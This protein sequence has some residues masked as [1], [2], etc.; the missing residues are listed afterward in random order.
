MVMVVNDNNYI[1]F[2][3]KIYYFH[4]R[5]F[6]KKKAITTIT[7]NHTHLIIITTLNYFHICRYQAHTPNAQNIILIDNKTSISACSIKEILT[8]TDAAVVA[9]VGSP[10]LICNSVNK[11]HVKSTV[12]LPLS[13]QRMNAMV[14]WISNMD[15]VL[16]G[17]RKGDIECGRMKNV[18]GY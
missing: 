5:C 12:K 1:P 16:Q 15:K 7:D 17:G 10:V 13:Q 3:E 4:H 18:D 14:M 11:H 9:S 6:H 2:T 8:R